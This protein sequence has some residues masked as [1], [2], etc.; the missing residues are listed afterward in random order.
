MKQKEQEKEDWKD[1]DSLNC[2]K[3]NR[4]VGSVDKFRFCPECAED[5]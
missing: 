1:G 5:E 4:F 2:I 3:C